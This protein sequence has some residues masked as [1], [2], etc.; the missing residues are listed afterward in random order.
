MPSPS[1]RSNWPSQT[2]S[3]PGTAAIAS[4]FSIPR[5]DSIW[6]M[7]TFSRLERSASA[8][9][10]SASSSLMSTPK[11]R[12]PSGGYFAQATSSSA[13]CADSTIGAM[14]PREPA[15]SADA[16]RSYSARMT[17]AI[18]YTPVPRPAASTRRSVP[19]SQPVCSRSKRAKSAPAAARI[20]MIPGVSNSNSIAPTAAPRSAMARDIAFSP[21]GTS[22]ISRPAAATVHEWAPP[23]LGMHPT[24]AAGG[25]STGSARFRLPSALSSQPPGGRAR[26]RRCP[27]SGMLPQPPA[28]H[29]PVRTPGRPRL[30][31]LFHGRGVLDRGLGPAHRRLR[32]VPA[33]P[34]RV[35]DVGGA[36]LGDRPRR[37]HRRPAVRRAARRPLPA[38]HARHRG[39]PR[40]AGAGRRRWRRSPTRARRRSR[41]S[42]CSRSSSGSATASSFRRSPR[43][44]RR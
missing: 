25:R 6:A 3:T 20:R 40:P 41:R 34:H 29:E 2:R 18:G 1:V 11:P 10:P 42:T 4:A 27:K 31:A 24:T 23:R 13:S 28:P 19:A 33:R 16:I 9:A 7:T 5:G 22:T 8:P 44:S 32:L 14:M 36:R 26:P 37:R 35:G 21:I 39:R 17:R 38:P 30:P 15:S 12:R 43:C